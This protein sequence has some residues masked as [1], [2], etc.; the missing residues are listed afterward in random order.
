MNFWFGKLQI[1]LGSR[2]VVGAI[3]GL[4]FAARYELV[5]LFCFQLYSNRAF[6]RWRLRL[7]WF[8]IWRSWNTEQNIIT[9]I[10]VQRKCLSRVLGLV[11]R[12]EQTN[13]FSCLHSWSFQYNWFLTTFVCISSL[14][15]SLG[16]TL[17]SPGKDCL[18]STQSSVGVRELGS[19]PPYFRDQPGNQSVSKEQQ[20]LVYILCI[21]QLLVVGT[22]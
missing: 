14:A 3:K 12:L 18:N 19:A 21:L 5:G 22:I 20:H 17:S 16:S 7:E 11:M 2:D 10:A 8:R 6:W 15:M 1:P 13:Q 9:E 4:F